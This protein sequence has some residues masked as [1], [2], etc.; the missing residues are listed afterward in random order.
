MTKKLRTILFSLILVFSLI[1]IAGYQ[2]IEELEG[3][4]KEV[5]TETKAEIKEETVEIV[6]ETTIAGNK[7]KAAEIPREIK[8]EAVK[9]VRELPIK[10]DKEK[11]AEIIRETTITVDKEK[12]AEIPREIKDEAVENVREITII[13]Y[14]EK[15]PETPE[16]PEEV[17]IPNNETDLP[18][19]IITVPTPILIAEPDYIVSG[20]KVSVTLEWYPVNHVNPVKYF[21]RFFCDNVPEHKEGWIVGTRWTREISSSCNYSWDV[22]ARDD[23]VHQESAWSAPDPFIVEV[24]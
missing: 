7:E 17:I 20:S 16:D 24:Y 12:A 3:K 19:E 5:A 23:V 6:R 1:L 11:A 21:L 18:E 14:K 8:E 15:A 10:E 2:K 13:G 4:V 22:K 9:I